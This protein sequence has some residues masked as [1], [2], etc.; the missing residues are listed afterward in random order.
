MSVR[1]LLD[2]Q[3]RVAIVTGGSRGLGLQ[4][5]EALGEMGAKLALTARKQDE[6]DEAIRHLG[7]SGIAAHA[8]LCDIGRRDA[9]PGVCNPMLHKPGAHGGKEGR[10]WWAPAPPG[11]GGERGARLGLRHRP[12]GDDSRRVR[13]DARQAG[14]H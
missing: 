8:W 14:A 2:L 7:A 1:Q 3:G 6:L 11:R 5:A 9:I 4:I 10:V 12:A 13:P